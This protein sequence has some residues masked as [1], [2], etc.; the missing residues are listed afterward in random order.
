MGLSLN[1]YMQTGTTPM[2]T[3]VRL[4]Q[5]KMAQMCPF[6]FIKEGFTIRVRGLKMD[7]QIM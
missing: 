3:Y 7:E 2:E 5:L 4:M 6:F 1:L